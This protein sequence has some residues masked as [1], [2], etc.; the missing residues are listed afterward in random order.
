MKDTLFSSELID[1]QL[2]AGAGKAVME[3]P[4]E[5]FPQESFSGIH[6]NIHVR[7]VILEGNQR[8]AI[9]SL[10]LTSLPAPE[11]QLLKELVHSITGIEFDHIWICATHSFSSPHFL[12]PHMLLDEASN[13]KND[14]LRQAVRQAVHK[15]VLT[16]LSMKK[17][18]KHQYW[19]WQ[20]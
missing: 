9:I 19:L 4:K 8:I 11:V 17:R 1:Q 5:F 14:M 2:I 13:M 3:V 20:L 6:D 12:P 18:S 15:A 16:A 10:E 7:A